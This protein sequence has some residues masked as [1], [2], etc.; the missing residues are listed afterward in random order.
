M[1]TV[2]LNYAIVTIYFSYKV[3]GFLMD[4]A[5]GMAFGAMGI[6][7]TIYIWAGVMPQT[8]DAFVLATSVEMMKNRESVY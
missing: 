6:G 4:E 1:Q 8:L 7:L 2:Q 5:I 3:A